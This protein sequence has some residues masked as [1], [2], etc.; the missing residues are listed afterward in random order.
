ADRLR[1]RCG[2]AL[3]GP[4]GPRQDLRR[5]T[6]IHEGDRGD[7]SGRRDDAGGGGPRGGPLRLRRPQASAHAQ[8]ERRRVAGGVMAPERIP[9]WL[10]E[11]LAAGD[12][13]QA[14]AE[15]LR[16]RLAE[17]EGGLERLEAI[18]RSNERILSDHPPARVAAAIRQRADG[19]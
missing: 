8:G 19:A 4:L 6:G 14:E 15:A 2:V 17:E 12:M 11:R 5:G 13:P 10:L 7:A 3:A 1:R 9:D 18:L 16:R